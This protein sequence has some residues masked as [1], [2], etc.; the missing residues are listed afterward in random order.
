M[1]DLWRVSPG[2]RVILAANK[3]DLTD[4]QQLTGID[5][6]NYATRLNMPYYLTSA[7][8]GDRVETL[9]RH[10]GMLMLIRHQQARP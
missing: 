4:K 8:S 6:E 2:A 7:K 1:D 3:A 9:F 5:I 10:L